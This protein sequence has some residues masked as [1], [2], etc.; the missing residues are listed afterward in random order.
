MASCSL[1]SGLLVVQRMKHKIYKKIVLVVLDGFGVASYSHGNAIALA[2][3][4]SLHNLVA[5]YPSLTL[6]A[7]GPVVGLPW[8]EVGNSEVGHLNMGAG[9]IVGQDLPRINAAIQDKS[10]FKNPV[11]LDAAAHVKK[12]KS[13]LHVMGM[14]SGGGVHSSE[15]HMYALLGFAEEQGIKEVFIHMFTD[16]RDTGER[17]ALDAVKKFKRKISEIGVGSIAT[18]TGRFLCHGPRQALG[19]NGNDVSGNGAWRWQL[20]LFR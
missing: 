2:N 6:Q 9:R 1:A 4:E 16:G 19:S 13:K 12:N 7:S 11:L 17:V 8:G 15:E 10:F 20:G 5:H 14:V 18:I 3:P